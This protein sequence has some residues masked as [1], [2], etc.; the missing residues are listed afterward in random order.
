MNLNDHAP[1]AHKPEKPKAEPYEIRARIVP[2]EAVVSVIAILRSRA[3]EAGALIEALENSTGATLTN[4]P[5][6]GGN[7]ALEP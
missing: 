6:R 1:E 3:K 4:V 5:P 2:E 7:G